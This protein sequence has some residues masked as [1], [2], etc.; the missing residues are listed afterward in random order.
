MI[1]ERTVELGVQRGQVLP[2]RGRTSL[3]LPATHGLD[4][5]LFKPFSLLK[6]K[7]KM[8]KEKLLVC[9][10]VE[11]SSLFCLHFVEMF[12]WE[13]WTFII[14]LACLAVLDIYGWNIF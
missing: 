2:L 9:Y 12:E 1:A 14:N 10:Y 13:S 4:F 8:L 6:N 7:S 5:G 11:L 3:R